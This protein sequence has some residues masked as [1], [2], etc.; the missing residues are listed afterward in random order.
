[1]IEA[2]PAADGFPEITPAEVKDNPGGNFP[3]TKDQV[4]GGTPPVAARV[5]EYATPTEPVGSVFVVITSPDVPPVTTSF[6][7][8]GRVGVAN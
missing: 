7:G 2:L 5:A 3:E 4:Y 1:V 8:M 6:T